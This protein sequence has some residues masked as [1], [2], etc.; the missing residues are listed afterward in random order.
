MRG[1]EDFIGYGCDYVNYS[2]ASEADGRIISVDGFALPANAN[3]AVPN[4]V[5]SCTALGTMCR[6]FI[7][8]CKIL[9]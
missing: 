9:A 3:V 8:F 6:F 2:C 7:L 5:M 4:Q 1:L